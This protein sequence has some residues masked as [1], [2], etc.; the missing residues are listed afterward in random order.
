MCFWLVRSE[1]FD[2]VLVEATSKETA[3]FLAYDALIIHPNTDPIG[4]KADEWIIEP[5]TVQEAIGM[6][7]T[8]MFDSS[9]SLRVLI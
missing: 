5:L 9:I 2:P 4:I 1:E 8:R 7:T 3:Y 6:V